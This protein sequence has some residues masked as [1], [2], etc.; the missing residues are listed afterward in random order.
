M[1]DKFYVGIIYHSK[2]GINYEYREKAVL[3]L[4]DD[5][6]YLHLES[7]NIY[8]TSR[9]GKDYVEE[10]SLVPAD[11]EDFRI[12]YKFLLDK[13]KGTHLSLKK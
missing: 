11:I 6:K 8:E 13:F 4:L 7:G 2:R 10:D 5:G 3:Y 1:E 12:D 9:E